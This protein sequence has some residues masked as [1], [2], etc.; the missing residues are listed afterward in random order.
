MGRPQ[1][2]RALTGIDGKMPPPPTP[3]ETL[4]RLGEAVEA[5]LDTLTDLKADVDYELEQL[6]RAEEIA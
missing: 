6:R 1:Q 5:M 2:H 3:N 4:A